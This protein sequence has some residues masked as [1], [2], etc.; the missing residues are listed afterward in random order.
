MSAAAPWTEAR[1]ASLGPDEYSFQE[2]K[3]SPYVVRDGRVSSTFVTSLSKQ[4]SAFA[5]GGGG[6]I[7]LGVDDNGVIDGGI[8][9]DAK[10]GGIKAW[11]EDVIPGS[12]DPPLGVFEVW[13][14]R[15]DP[16]RAHSLIAPG[17]A[18]YV[19]DIPQS[20]LAP[21]MAMDFR[22]YLRLAGKSRPMGNLNVQDVIT[23]TRTPRVALARIGPYGPPVKV[24][25]DARGPKVLLCFQAFVQNTG[26]VMAQHLG[27]ELTLPRPLVTKEVRRRIG[28]EAQEVAITQ[29]PGTIRFFRYL[30]QP[31]FPGQEMRVLHFWISL[32]RNNGNAVQ[33]GVAEMIWR[34]YADDA[35]AHVEARDFNSYGVV[36]DALWWLRGSNPA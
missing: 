27:V 34:I 29:N 23:R 14:V 20:D 36:N 10:N 3:A 16:E 13:E 31:L 18:C 28:E 15:G 6:R 26:K 4:V 22:Y 33:A 30:P 21:H 11:L 9:V 19:I 2:F 7:F 5:N 12:V 25:T 17:H 8:P 32:H 35:P 1:L 24:E